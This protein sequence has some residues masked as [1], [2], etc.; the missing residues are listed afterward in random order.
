M[1]VMLFA[2]DTSAGRAWY[3]WSSACEDV[4]GFLS[5]AEARAYAD[6]LTEHSDA[7]RCP[8]IDRSIEQGATLI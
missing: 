8:Y 3:V 7:L 2:S 5:M 1:I 6:A 4:E